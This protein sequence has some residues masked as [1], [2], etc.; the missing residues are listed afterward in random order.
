MTSFLLSVLS[1][2]ARG[3]LAGASSWP[4]DVLRRLG[5]STG[6]LIY[7]CAKSKVGQDLTRL[8]DNDVGCAET[9]SRI[10]QAVDPSYLPWIVT[11][12]ASL[13]D[14]LYQDTKHWRLVPHFDAKPGDIILSPTG[15]GN[16]TIKNGHTGIVGK[17]CIL[18]NNSA[19]G[20][21][22]THLTLEQWNATFGKKG[23]FPIYYFRAK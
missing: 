8:A 18:S 3:K 14:L 15:K 9:V 16:G 19:T 20:R 5:Y 1:F 17:T 11:G 4:Y 12:T 23:G 7:A 13:F 2:I 10:V 22:D 21:L 6:S